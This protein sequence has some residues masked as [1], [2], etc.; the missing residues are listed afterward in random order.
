MG[1][2]WLTL[3]TTQVLDALAN[4]LGG[5]GAAGADVVDLDAAGDPGAGGAD[6]QGAHHGGRV[7]GGDGDC[8][9]WGKDGEGFGRS[10]D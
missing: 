1:D 4:V 5:G 8:V 10:E 7:G 6:A 2:L 3:D 9:V